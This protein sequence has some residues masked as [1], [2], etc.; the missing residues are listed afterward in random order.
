MISVRSNLGRLGA[1]PGLF[2]DVEALGVSEL[3]VQVP[4]VD[5]RRGAVARLLKNLCQSLVE[6]R[7]VPFANGQAVLRGVEAREHRGEAPTSLGPVGEGKIER[8]P[9][10]RQLVEGRTGLPRVAVGAQVVRPQRVDGDEEHVDSR[11]AR[12]VRRL[13][14]R[15]LAPRQE[16]HRW[17]EQEAPLHG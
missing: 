10:R 17:R 2:V 15:R 11:V 4:V 6:L 9:L 13:G 14:R 7:K 3:A 5:G 1:K 12:S 16:E 8:H